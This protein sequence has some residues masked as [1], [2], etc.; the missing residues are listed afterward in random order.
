MEHENIILEQWKE[1]FNHCLA[2]EFS[3][4]EYFAVH[5]LMVL[6]YMLQTDSYSTVFFPKA[7]ILLKN[8]LNETVETNVNRFQKTGN[9]NISKD[10][11]E[12]NYFRFHWN[13]TIL[14]IRTSNSDEYCSD[15]REWAYDVVN[16]IE[17]KAI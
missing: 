10:A 2:L 5:H 17:G 15:V 7:V 3:N 9:I 1:K 8:F 13:K 12:S 6:C 14:S 4:P 11:K 16:T